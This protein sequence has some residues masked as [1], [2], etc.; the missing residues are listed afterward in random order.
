MMTAWFFAP[1]LHC[2]LFP[3]RRALGTRSTCERRNDSK[4]VSEPVI[5]VLSS[6]V[7]SDE[8]DRLDVGVVTDGVNGRDCSVDNVKNAGW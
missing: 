7:A 1:M 4:G 8:T 5:N 3:A 2:A 6:L